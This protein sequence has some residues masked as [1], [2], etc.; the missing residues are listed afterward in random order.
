MIHDAQM[1][2]MGSPADLREAADLGDAVSNDIAGIYAARAGG[3]PSAWRSAMT[4]TTWYSAQESVDAGLADSVAG[5]KS[6]T[7]GA[8]L[9]ARLIKAR[10]AV[11]LGGV[12]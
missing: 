11:A 5:A 1:I 6:K 4:A 8:N 10:A 7:S 9:A 12:K 2:A 3:K